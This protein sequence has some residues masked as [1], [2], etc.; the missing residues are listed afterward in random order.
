MT[1]SHQTPTP[2]LPHGPSSHPDL[3]A[4]PPGTLLHL[5]PPIRGQDRCLQL[6]RD[7]Y[8]LEAHGVSQPLDAD[9]ARAAWARR[10]T[11]RLNADTPEQRAWIAAQ[12]R[13]GQR[14]VYMTQTRGRHGHLDLPAY[15]EARRRGDQYEHGT[16]DGRL[17]PCP[18]AHLDT[19]LTRHADAIA[20][21]GTLIPGGTP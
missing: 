21:N 3:P 18:A 14:L 9:T 8:S 15:Y 11:G 20:L 1:Q 19:Y 17:F 10:T 7:G 12:L 5:T 4:G 16:Q 2:R 13:L 6:R